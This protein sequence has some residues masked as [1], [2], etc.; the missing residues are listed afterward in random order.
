MTQ[1]GL[2]SRGNNVEYPRFRREWS[3]YRK[4]YHAH[5]RDEFVCC[6]LKEKCLFAA[7]NAV[8]GDM[9]ELEKVLETL[10]T[11]YYR[12]E[13]YIAEALEPIIKFRKYKVFEH[14]AIRSSTHC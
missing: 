12:L 7:A 14:A 4:T 6:T 10:D 11:L 13:K 9:E 5:I 1:G 2:S 3:A 8:V